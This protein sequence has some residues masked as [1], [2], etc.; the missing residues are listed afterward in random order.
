MSTDLAECARARVATRGRGPG[1]D[2]IPVHGAAYGRRMLV[3]LTTPQ[4]ERAMRQERFGSRREFKR[5]E[6]L[7]RRHFLECVPLDESAVQQKSRFV[8]PEVAVGVAVVIAR[9]RVPDPSDVIRRL[10]DERDELLL[11]REEAIAV[12]RGLSR[13]L[14]ELAKKMK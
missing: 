1:L 2:P 5:A 11:E 3:L 7:A 9:G 10:F 8:R 12:V 6:M 4:F 14:D 13:R